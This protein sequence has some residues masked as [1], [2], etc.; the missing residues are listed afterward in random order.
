MIR[1]SLAHRES[2]VLRD[3]AVGDCIEG[4]EAIVYMFEER[5][6][7]LNPKNPSQ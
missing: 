1:I 4:I 3:I 6:F 5:V 2:F 7:G